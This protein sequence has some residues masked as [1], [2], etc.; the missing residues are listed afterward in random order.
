MLQALKRS[1]MALQFASE[2]LRCDREVVL[3]AA[4]QDGCSVRFAFYQA[5]RE[6]FDIMKEAI[7]NDWR[8]YGYASNELKRNKDLALFA[9]EQ[10]WETLQFVDEDLQDD[11][12]VMSAA[13]SQKGEALRYASDRLRIHPE[14]VRKADEMGWQVVT[15]GNDVAL[16]LR[17]QGITW[18]PRP[19]R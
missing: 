2:A 3:E 8:S 11:L 16:Q 1:G 12:E 14:L 18:A 15:E 17:T 13:V 9:I 7:A 10:S 19:V 6:D 4:R 5:F